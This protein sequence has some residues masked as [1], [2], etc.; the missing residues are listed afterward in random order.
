MIR[1]STA[2]ILALCLH[3]GLFWAEMPWSRPTLLTP[4]S[5][6]VR[7]DLVTFQKPVEKAA[8]RK[9]KV[10]K[11]KLKP[12]PEPVVK[13]V[14]PPPAVPRPAPP[15]PIPQIVEAAPAIEPPPEA[16]AVSI[17]P[18]APVV[19][20]SPAAEPDDRAAVQ[21]S[22]PR[23]DINPPPHYPRVARRRNYQGTVLLDVRVTVEGLVAQVR[24]AESSGYSVLDKSAVKSVKGWHFTPARRGR[25]PIEMWVQVPVRYELQ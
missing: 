12:K 8:P 20:E 17:D 3:A 14:T 22:V 5:R 25:T 18:N 21:A 16:Q 24:I 2:A 6:V 4:Q 9:P 7:I 15:E 10:I 19:E 11:P 23:Y 1:L 13:P